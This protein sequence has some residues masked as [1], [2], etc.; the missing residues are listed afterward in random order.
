MI[1]G[2]FVVISRLGV[3]TPNEP[4]QRLIPSKTA[5]LTPDL[6]GA[7]SKFLPKVCAKYVACSL[8]KPAKSSLV[9]KG[10]DP[11]Y[12]AMAKTVGYPLG[13]FVKLFMDGDIKLKGVH[14]PVIKE[15]YEPVL[16]EL[17]SF[18]INF[19]EESTTLDIIISAEPSSK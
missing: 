7:C 8:G 10:D 1:I 6:K 14:L 3:A 19:I 17:S 2:V 5:A 12:T 11:E 15:I 4:L 13:V 18:G 9:V 16:K